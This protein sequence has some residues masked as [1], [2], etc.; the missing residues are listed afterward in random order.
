MTETGRRVGGQILVAAAAT[1]AG[2]LAFVPTDFRG[3]AE[4]GLIAG[5]RAC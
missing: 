2:F 1:A 5:R 4:L 3:V